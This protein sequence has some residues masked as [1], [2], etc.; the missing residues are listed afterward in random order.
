M[1]VCEGVREVQLFV[2]LASP[3]REQ[4]CVPAP[5]AS[6]WCHLEQGGHCGKG[7]LS[8]VLPG[9]GCAGKLVLGGTNLL[10]SP[11]VKLF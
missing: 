10:Q 6:S 7:T 11:Q 4:C 8:S 9:Q 1:H 2:F 5:A 3:E